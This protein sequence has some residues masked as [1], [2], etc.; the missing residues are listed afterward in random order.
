LKKKFNSSPSILLANVYPDYN[1]LPWKFNTYPKTFWDD[2]K[3]QRKFMEW[4]ANELK[5]KGMS[6]WYDVTFKV[7]LPQNIHVYF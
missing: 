6:N 4:A 2:V 5:I 3:N 1:W 7:T